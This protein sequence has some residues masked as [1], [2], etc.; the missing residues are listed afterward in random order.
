MVYHIDCERVCGIGCLIFII[1]FIP[2]I[3]IIIYGAF[4]H[5]DFCDG[6]HTTCNITIINYE[7]NWTPIDDNLTDC[8][9]TGDIIVTLEN[10]DWTEVYCYYIILNDRCST[11]ECPPIS[12]KKL[13]LVIN[14]PCIIVMTQIVYIS[15]FSC[16]RCNH[17]GNVI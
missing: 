16:W 17:M 3:P 12:G 5:G 2:S 13:A 14:G 8:G 7:S 15:F 11:E 4:K 1:T 9:Y 10:N 6:I